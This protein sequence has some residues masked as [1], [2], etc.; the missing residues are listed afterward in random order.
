METGSDEV[1]KSFMNEYYDNLFD[2][3]PYFLED[4]H[5]RDQKAQFFSW[6]MPQ[7]K[8]VEGTSPTTSVTQ[9]SYD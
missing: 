6:H 8:K 7:L 3:E 9:N 4:V 2:Q 1:T 5:I